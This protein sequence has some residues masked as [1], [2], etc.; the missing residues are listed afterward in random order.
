MQNISYTKLIKRHCMH[1]EKIIQHRF[2][3]CLNLKL[4]FKSKNNFEGSVIVK[5]NQNQL[6]R[7]P[8]PAGF[9]SVVGSR[10]TRRGGPSSESYPSG[11]RTRWPRSSLSSSPRSAATSHSTSKTMNRNKNS[12]GQFE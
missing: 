11:P 3:S 1:M 10:W 8:V 9:L 5:L 4:H 6:C 12:I 2:Q 7:V